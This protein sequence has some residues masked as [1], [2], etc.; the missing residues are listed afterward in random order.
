MVGGAAHFSLG[1]EIAE[2]TGRA[3]RANGDKHS[4]LI[5]VLNSAQVFIESE[6][7]SR[8]VHF[9]GTFLSNR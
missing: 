3:R 4:R 9:D 8:K 2:G 1:A 5:E 7:V 6:I